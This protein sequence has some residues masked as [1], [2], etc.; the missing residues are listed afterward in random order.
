MKL[1]RDPALSI[2]LGISGDTC[3]NLE[4]KPFSLVSAKLTQKYPIHNLNL[5]FSEDLMKLTDETIQ[6]MLNDEVFELR[7]RSAFDYDDIFMGVHKRQEN[8]TKS[9]VILNEEDRLKFFWNIT[10]FKGN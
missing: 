3:S 8:M 4:N 1:L 7:V 6:D 9:E 5:T 10:E 2:S